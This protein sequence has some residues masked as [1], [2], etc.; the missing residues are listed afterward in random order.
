MADNHKKDDEATEDS[1][2]VGG[3]HTPILPD[4][5]LLEKLADELDA[6]ERTALTGVNAGTN[7]NQAPS[8]N[9]AVFASSIETDPTDSV[10]TSG[11]SQV[12]SDADSFA[13]FVSETAGATGNSEAADIGDGQGDP[14]ANNGDGQDGLLVDG[15]DDQDNPV[16]DNGSR[17]EDRSAGGDDEQVS[18]PD[19]AAADNGDSQGT[20]NGQVASVAVSDDSQDSDL[21][22]P[23]SE[24]S[25]SQ[26]AQTTDT[27]S[28]RTT[29]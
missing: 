3:E 29:F 18:D 8:E 11:V 9:S 5:E 2:P 4:E 22:S 15:G 26:G 19:S 7:I 12:A 16:D 24:S 13:G 25:G 21:Y 10:G 1:A 27:S 23:T 17:Q 14:L 28:S 20:S 6:D